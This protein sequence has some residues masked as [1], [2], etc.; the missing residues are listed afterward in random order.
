MIL[1]ICDSPNMMQTMNIVMTIIN[2]II[3]VVPI[4]LLFSL[5]FKLINASVKNNQDALKDVKK[6]A[7]P[8]IITAFLILI[9]GTLSLSVEILS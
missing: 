8:N 5:M 4:L 7:I 6:K 3:I 9:A 1:D 2:I